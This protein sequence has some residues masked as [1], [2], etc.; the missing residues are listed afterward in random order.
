[1]EAAPSTMR[2][3]MMDR[4][5]LIVAVGIAL[6]LFLIALGAILFDI[7]NQ[8]FVGGPTPEQAVTNQNLQQV[9]GPLLTHLGFFFLIGG[10]FWGAIFL[11]SSD[12]FIRLILLIL[13]LI[14]LLLVL[15]NSPTIFG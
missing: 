12:P 6:G 8:A 5:R 13:G 9:W 3:L 14:A 11:E 10:L 4:N 2:G 1:M 7:G 15:A